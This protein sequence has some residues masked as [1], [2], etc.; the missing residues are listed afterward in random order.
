MTDD[1][2]HRC[3]DCGEIGRQKENLNPFDRLDLYCLDE[4]KSCYNHAL[5][6][7]QPVG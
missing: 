3:R 1:M 6:K 4:E 5:R 2:I 7:G